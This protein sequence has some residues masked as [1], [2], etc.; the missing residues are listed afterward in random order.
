MK[1]LQ[2]IMAVLVLVF[3]FAAASYEARIALQ[4]WIYEEE[5]NACWFLDEKVE[6]VLIADLAMWAD[7]I[8]HSPDVHPEDWFNLREA[9]LVE[10]YS[11]KGIT[12]QEAFACL[13]SLE[14]LIKEQ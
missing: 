4:N 11:S 3:L 9:E 8:Q 5:T 10:L 14:P 1:R 13:T 2:N 7:H 12:N 6:R